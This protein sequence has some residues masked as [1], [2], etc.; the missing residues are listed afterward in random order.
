MLD[1]YKVLLGD[2]TES[3]E[4]HLDSEIRAGVIGVQLNFSAITRHLASLSKVQQVAITQ[5]WAIQLKLLL[6]MPAANAE[7]KRSF[8]ALC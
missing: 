3:Q 6:V 5:V 4:G 1:N 7:S 8:S 2:W